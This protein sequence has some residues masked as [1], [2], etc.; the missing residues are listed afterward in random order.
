MIFF[1]EFTNASWARPANVTLVFSFCGLL[2]IISP[3]QI[4]FAVG[5]PLPSRRRFKTLLAMAARADEHTR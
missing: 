1:V 5:Q 4:L 2:N 3:P